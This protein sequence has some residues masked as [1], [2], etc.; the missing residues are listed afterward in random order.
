MAS[1]RVERAQDLIREEVSRLL[2][3]KI[4]DPRLKSVTITSVKMTGDLKK[5]KV[6]YSVFDDSADR[7][8]IEQGL[9]KAAGFFRRELGH[10][11]DLKYIP[12]I[13]FEFDKSLEYAQHMDKILSDINEGTERESCE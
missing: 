12:E 13:R 3:M 8:A 11:L 1:R 6:L 9:A 2:L 5:A 4:K 7:K 10:V